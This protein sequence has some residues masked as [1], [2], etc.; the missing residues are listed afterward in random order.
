MV[1]WRYAPRRSRRR[2]REKRDRKR[3]GFTARSPTGSMR[4]YWGMKEV[5]FYNGTLMNKQWSTC[6]CTLSIMV[7]CQLCKVK[8]LN[9]IQVVKQWICLWVIRL[10]Y[11]NNSVLLRPLRQSS[12]LCL[13]CYCLTLIW[14]GKSINMV[15]T[16]STQTTPTQ[17]I[18]ISAWGRILGV[19]IKRHI[20][21]YLCIPVYYTS[22]CI[23]IISIMNN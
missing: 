16:N 2:Q 8:T 21:T 6:K 17:S 3:S 23:T 10:P 4:R 19:A 1:V 9:F 5:Q 18:W 14:E 11:L 20:S 13:Y 22:Q 15:I 12:P 7:H